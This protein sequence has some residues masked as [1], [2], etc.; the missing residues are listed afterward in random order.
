MKLNI[1]ATTA[2]LQNHASFYWVLQNSV[3][4]LD[5]CFD[6]GVLSTFDELVFFSGHTRV[7]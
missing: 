3:Q 7:K 6:D 2:K 4:Q 1:P 5:F